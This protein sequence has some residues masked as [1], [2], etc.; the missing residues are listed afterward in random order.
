MAQPYVILE[1]DSPAQLA[2]YVNK[3]IAEGWL[4]N[5]GPVAVDILGDYRWFQ[6][7]IE[8]TAAMQILGT[9]ADSYKGK[10]AQDE[11]DAAFG[12]DHYHVCPSCN[13]RLGCNE[14]AEGAGLYCWLGLEKMLGG[15]PCDT[16]PA[17]LEH[18][19]SPIIRDTVKKRSSSY[20]GHCG[21][22]RRGIE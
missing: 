18:K 20:C 15:D 16:V 12:Y 5:G 8:Q 2:D 1:A 6:P 22:K 11:I 14:D 19:C 3:A 7:M 10:A 4:P 21:A 17:I 9:A 13:M